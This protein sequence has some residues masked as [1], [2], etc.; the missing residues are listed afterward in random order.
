MECAKFD[1]P[2]H[3]VLDCQV[4]AGESTLKEAHCVFKCEEGFKLVYEGFIGHDFSRKNTV[5]ENSV[6]AF[7][8]MCQHDE[9]KTHNF[10]LPECE[11]LFIKL[12]IIVLSGISFLS[13]K[14]CCSFK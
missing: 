10:Y 13:Y 12:F 1:A 6:H 7:D 5:K 4:R 2:Q 9:Y 14:N 8:V 3:G 11:S